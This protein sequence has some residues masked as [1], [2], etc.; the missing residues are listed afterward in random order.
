MILRRQSASTLVELWIVIFL[1]AVL[2]VLA[3]F[4]LNENKSRTRDLTRVHDIKSLQQALELYRQKVGLYPSSLIS[5]QP[6]R[7]PAGEMLIAKVPFNP[8]PANCYIAGYSYKPIDG[9]KNYNLVFCLANQY[10]NINAGRCVADKA[11]FC[12]ILGEGCLSANCIW[13][14]VG[15]AGFSDGAADSDWLNMN[16]FSRL[17][18]A[19][20]DSQ[21]GNEAGVM[22]YD[23]GDKTPS[24]IDVQ[25]ASLSSLQ[26]GQVGSLTTA[27]W[28]HDNSNKYL[29]LAYSD[30][31]A[32]GRPKVLAYQYQKD[33][34]WVAVNG[35]LPTTAAND[36]VMIADQKTA[37]LAYQ[38]V[39]QSGKV[40]VM[41]NDKLGT[42][43]LV[44]SRGFSAGEAREISL[45]LNSDL[46]IAYLDESLD[47]VVVLKNSGSSW[48]KLGASQTVSN[49]SAS[50][51]S[52]TTFN[53]KPCVAYVD[54]SADHKA[55]V[56][57]FNGTSWQA[58]G[59]AGISV[60]QVD[61]TM[62]A[63]YGNNLYISYL[64]K[65]NDYKITV[66]K[67]TGT[68]WQTVGPAGFSPSGARDPFLTIYNNN[69][70]VGFSDPTKG[71]KISV[72]S[73]Q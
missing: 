17:F 43:T 18:I 23:F 47:K 5:G 19:Y 14:Y 68:V 49:G 32:G 62:L 38:D 16:K 12:N 2:F 70:Y 6:L 9:G 25:P 57:C 30:L 3:N 39:A 20:R 65:Y 66:M 69:L 34:P 31:G 4:M 59:G 46:Y 42:W 27:V 48:I 56:M 61:N 24:W 21:A 29:Y 52:L 67:W 54:Y 33:K 72:M 63:S 45:D 64:D 36:L 53:S 15:L 73:Y 10:S 41:S 26:S 11:N 28:D 8:L 37:Y 55:T 44:G 51:I 7:T 60:G 40:T 13:Q 50:S 22:S 1:I 58:L 71:G 35:G